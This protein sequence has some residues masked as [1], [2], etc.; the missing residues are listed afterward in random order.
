LIE[1][2]D[3]ERAVGVVEDGLNTFK[4]TT[5]LRWLAADLYRE[6]NPDAYRETLKQLFLDHSEWDAYDELKAAC[7]DQEW[8]S[9]RDE[10]VTALNE[11]DRRRLID[12]YILEGELENAFAE[13]VAS[14]NLSWFQRY[15]GSVAS[16]D[17]EAYFEAYKEL[18]VPFAAGETGRSHYKEIAHHLKQM[19]AL[20]SEDRFRE[21]VDGLKDKHSNRPAFLD[22]LRKADF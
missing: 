12:V 19:Q 17:P 9:I 10:I 11:T 5:T 4:S 6:R 2:G 14:E 8:A 21:F 13:V 7:D 3:T 16:V 20:I 1:R 18:L 22:E 15:R